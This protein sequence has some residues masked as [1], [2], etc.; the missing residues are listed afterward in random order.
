MNFS[1]PQSNIFFNAQS[2]DNISFG[3]KKQRFNQI[4]IDNKGLE[5]DTVSFSGNKETKPNKSTEDISTFEGIGKDSSENV[6]VN[7]DRYSNR[8]KELISARVGYEVN[9]NDISNMDKGFSSQYGIDLIEYQGIKNSAF[10]ELFEN[11]N[12]LEIG[13]NKR[14]FY[15]TNE[16]KR[17]FQKCRDNIDKSF[18]DEYCKD[19]I[20]TDVMFLEA[21]AISAGID[22]ENKTSKEIFHEIQNQNLNELANAIGASSS[23]LKDYLEAYLCRDSF[24]ETLETATQT[25]T[26]EIVSGD[27]AVH[28]L[29]KALAQKFDNDSEFRKNFIEHCQNSEKYKDY[30][31]LFDMY[32]TDLKIQ[33]KNMGCKKPDAFVDSKIE[34][35]NHLISRAVQRDATADFDSIK[36]KDFMEITGDETENYS[37]SYTLAKRL[38]SEDI[39]PNEPFMGRILTMENTNKI[40]TIEYHYK[41]PKE[42]WDKNAVY[43][44]KAG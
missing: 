4:G 41:N 21:M 18:N 44:P 11:E 31:A 5:K 26:K 13:D 3:A 24:S 12:L 16:Q 43:I 19:V 20:M 27:K 9:D 8:L 40:Q 30:A 39:D 32:K 34:N 6:F 17:L 38:L 35:I 23:G 37:L 33:L 2:K 15:V 14:K 36:E 22:I 28:E 7:A 10:I 29:N 25:G 1:I 42:S